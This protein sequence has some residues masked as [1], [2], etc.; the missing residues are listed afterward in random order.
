VKYDEVKKVV[1]RVNR[2]DIVYINHII[3]SYDGVMLMTTL[4]PA[5]AR[6]EFNISPFL[7]GEALTILRELSKETSLEI[8]Q[9]DSSEPDK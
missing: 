5:E 8:I 1:A 7:Y 9:R 2:R 4:D 3:E 6:V